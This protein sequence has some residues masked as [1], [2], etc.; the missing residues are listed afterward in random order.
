MKISGKILVKGTSNEMYKGNGK[1][2]P[3]VHA[4]GV[5]GAPADLDIGVDLPAQ[6]DL[7]NK[8]GKMVGQAA[9]VVFDMT[10]FNQRANF[11]LISLESVQVKP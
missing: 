10:F 3:K 9:T 1:Y 5:E 6:N 8:A 11:A 2:Y 4:F 7:F